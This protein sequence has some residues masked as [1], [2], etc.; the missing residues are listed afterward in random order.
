MKPYTPKTGNPCTCRRGIERDNCPKCEGSGWEINFHALHARK[1]RQDML[2][3]FWDAVA[4][5]EQATGQ[6]I[7]DILLA[8]YRKQGATAVALRRGRVL[9]RYERATPSPT[10]RRAYWHAITDR[11]MERL[12]ERLVI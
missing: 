8:H 3:R 11:G 9:V 10:G 1:Q 5:R 2:S 12:L 7:E 4:A 6:G